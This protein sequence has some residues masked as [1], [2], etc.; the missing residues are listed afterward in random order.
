M[1]ILFVSLRSDDLGL[2]SRLLPIVA[3][4]RARGHDVAFP[5][6]D[7]APAKLITSARFRNLECPPMRASGASQRPAGSARRTLRGIG[8]QVAKAGKAAAGKTPVKRNGSSSCP[9]APQCQ[10]DPARATVD[11]SDDRV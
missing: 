8:E 3:E 11:R 6:P 7:P 9:A 10:P 5:S 2:P 4:L 1:R